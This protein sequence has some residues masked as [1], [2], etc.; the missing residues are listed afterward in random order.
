MPGTA[1]MAAPDPEATEKLCGACH[2]KYGGIRQVRKP[3]E[4]AG[5]YL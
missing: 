5:V 2:Q 3:E 4:Q 1:E